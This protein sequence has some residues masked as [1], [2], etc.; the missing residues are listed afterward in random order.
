MLS[1]E[2]RGEEGKTKKSSCSEG[3]PRLESL[4]GNTP[5]MYLKSISESTGCQVYAKAEFMSPG[6]SVKDRIA[7]QIIK[8]A[9]EDKLIDQ[10][11]LVCEGTAGSTGVSLA[12]VA[13]AHGL[14]CFVAMPDDAAIE[15]VQLLEALGA[16]VER[17]RP[18]SIAHPR[19][20]VNVARRRAE[21][22]KEEKGSRRAALFADQV[23]ECCRFQ[24]L[25]H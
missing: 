19:H 5:L 7:L 8:E 18:V 24:G 4:I 10:G 13:A 22:E 14:R 3:L 20:H 12:M 25:M 6:G 11:G 21:K 9:I 2:N 15:K 17:V 16:E 23:G 1:K